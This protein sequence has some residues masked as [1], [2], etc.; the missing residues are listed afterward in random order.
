MAFTAQLDTQGGIEVTEV[1]CV[2][3]E[4]SFILMLCFLA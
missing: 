1:K 3:V 4:D 2:F